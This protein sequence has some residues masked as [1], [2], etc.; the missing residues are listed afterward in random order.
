MKVTKFITSFMKV[1]VLALF[2]A[3]ATPVYAEWQK[4]FN[5]DDTDFYVDLES[6][7]KGWS[8]SSYTLL[9]NYVGGADAGTS[10]VQ[11]V[12]VD[13][14]TSNHKMVRSDYYSKP[15]GRGR[16]T[17]YLMDD[18]IYPANGSVA[19]HVDKIVCAY[20]NSKK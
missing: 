19:A 4:L 12:K 6:I 15:F 2:L 1:A 18:W 14:K 11:S 5:Y 9:E 7:K 17:D 3:S 8:V 10:S 16:K 20:I 13:C